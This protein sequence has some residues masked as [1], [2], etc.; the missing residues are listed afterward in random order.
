MRTG[1]ERREGAMPDLPLLWASWRWRLRP[2]LRWLVAA[3]VAA[4][5]VACFVALSRQAAGAKAAWGER[6]AVAVVDADLPAGHVV[7]A[8]DV[9]LVELPLAVVPADAVGEVPEGAVLGSA[10]YAGEIL[11]ARRLAPEGTGPLAAQLAPGERAVTVG[12]GDG[13]LALRHGDHVELV[14]DRPL[15]TGRVLAVGE[16]S[17]TVAVPAD[18]VGTV[19]AALVQQQVVLALAP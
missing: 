18:D 9:R 17:V 10:V 19:A 16:A 13:D 11:V 15:A 3:A 7:S 4:A 12:H 8:G 1:V 14:T 5:A 2:A 6:R